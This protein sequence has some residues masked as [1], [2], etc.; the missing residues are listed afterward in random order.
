MKSAKARSLKVFLVVFSGMFV[1]FGGI[2][3]TRSVLDLPTTVALVAAVSA[4]V[5]L[6]W[7][8][9]IVVLG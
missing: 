1:V 2:F 3:G 8:V 6:V 7:V 9:A 5:A 4:V